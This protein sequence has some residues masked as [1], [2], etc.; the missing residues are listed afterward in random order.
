MCVLCRVKALLHSYSSH[1]TSD[2]SDSTFPWSHVIIT[3]I[4]HLISVAPADLWVTCFHGNS[5]DFA[6]PTSWMMAEARTSLECVHFEPR[7]PPSKHHHRN[8]S[9]SYLITPPLPIQAR[10]PLATKLAEEIETE[11]QLSIE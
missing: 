2:Q 1:M 6:I 11:K 7:P 3:C 5:K 8:L 4:D 9:D 10:L